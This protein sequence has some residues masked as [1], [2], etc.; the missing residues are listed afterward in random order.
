MIL[1]RHIERQNFIHIVQIGLSFN[2][3]KK[4]MDPDQLA[5]LKQ[6]NLDLN[7]FQ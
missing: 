3:A 7:C 2:T 4:T 6:V 5:C 1:Y